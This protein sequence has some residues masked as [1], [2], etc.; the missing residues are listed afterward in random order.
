MNKAATPA[1]SGHEPENLAIKRVCVII[2]GVFGGLIALSLVSLSIW[3]GLFEYADHKSPAAPVAIPP[4]PR[5]QAR[6]LPDYRQ[7]EV[8]KQ[9]Q[10]ETYAWDDRGQGVARIPL[11]AAMQVLTRDAPGAANGG[12]E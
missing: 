12:A 1:A 8:H 11:S 4:A 7:Y 2:G 9:Q 5:L 6:P 3:Q 10:L